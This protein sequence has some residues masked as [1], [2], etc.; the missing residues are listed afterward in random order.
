MIASQSPR[1]LRLG[2]LGVGWIGR[3]RMEAILRSGTADA[4]AIADSSANALEEAQ[5]LA[6]QA[7]L[8][9]TLDELLAVGV[10]GVVIATPSAL[11]AGQAL[12]AIEQ[13]IAVFCQKP[14]GR[15]AEE[16]RRVVEAAHRADRLLAVDLS[17]RQTQGL[18]RIRNLVAAGELGRIFAADMVFHNA[19]GPD[20]TW[21]YNR[22]LSGGGCV[23]DLGVHLVDAAL[24]ILGF[25]KVRE[26]SSH[27]FSNGEPFL[28]TDETVEDF[29]LASLVL[30]GDIAVR[31]ACSWR[32]QTGADCEISTVFHGAGGGAAMRNVSGSFYDFVTERYRGTATEALSEPPED[33]GG[34]AAVQWARALADGK[35]YDPDAVRLVE[36][37]HVLDRIYAGHS[38]L[39]SYQTIA[40]S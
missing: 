22:K 38:V 33:W 5:R 15:N 18:G 17:Y 37:A 21:F 1:R 34:R 12:Q 40:N 4:V 2:F 8:G 11:H 35:G 19:Y 28:P 29:G 26:V 36:V 7:V 16:T 9:E 6:P 30:E 10:D 25:P 24:W 39:N 23:M 31:I 14:L 20:K 32:A 3:H 13:G 27:L